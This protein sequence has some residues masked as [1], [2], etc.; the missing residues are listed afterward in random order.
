MRKLKKKKKR[1]CLGEIFLL[2]TDLPSSYCSDFCLYR[3][4]TKKLRS[5]VKHVANK[6]DFD[7]PLT[8]DQRHGKVK[9]RLSE[10]QAQRNLKRLPREILLL[11]IARSDIFLSFPYLL[12]ENVN[13][14]YSV[15]LSIQRFPS[16]CREKKIYSM[17]GDQLQ[18]FVFIHKIK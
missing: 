1:Y 8:P 12:N 13:D 18:D 10:F 6:G 4:F 11:Y 14:F 16:P 17:R 9:F 2:V 7:S 3:N 15:H 5:S